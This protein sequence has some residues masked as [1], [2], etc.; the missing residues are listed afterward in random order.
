MAVRNVG[1]PIA[2]G[3][4]ESREG[5]ESSPQTTGRGKFSGRV[6]I[7]YEQIRRTLQVEE[8]DDEA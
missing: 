8:A 2:L 5:K 3:L 7:V 6:K 1:S 4:L